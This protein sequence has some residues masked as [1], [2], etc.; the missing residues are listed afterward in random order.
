MSSTLAFASCTAGAAW[1]QARKSVA[2]TQFDKHSGTPQHHPKGTHA[3]L[4]TSLTHHVRKH[5]QLP[6]RARFD[7][8]QLN[9]KHL[10]ST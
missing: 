6:A 10:Q 5:R 9:I 4:R 8:T 1:L 2:A 3:S 7:L